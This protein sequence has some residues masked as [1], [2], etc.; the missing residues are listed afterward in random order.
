MTATAARAEIDTQAP[1]VRRA[2]YLTNENGF[3]F[4]WP[5]RPGAPVPGR[6]RSG[7]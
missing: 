4:S 7:L 6:A 3:A 2:R 1:Y 5:A